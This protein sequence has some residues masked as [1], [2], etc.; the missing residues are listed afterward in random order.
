MS[1]LKTCKNCAFFE[2]RSY[3]NHGWCHRYPRKILEAQTV[4]EFPTHYKWDWCGEWTKYYVRM[5]E[6]N[7]HNK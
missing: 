7:E 1:E 3:P 4:G 2:A 6:D 5:G